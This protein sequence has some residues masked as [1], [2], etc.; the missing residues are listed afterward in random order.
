MSTMLNTQ[1]SQNPKGTQQNSTTQQA[2]PAQ[3]STF[4]MYFG[5]SLTAALN[6]V[7]AVLAK[8]EVELEQEQ[9]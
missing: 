1:D 4:G 3:G 9:R 6:F 2:A 5:P 8:T 7:M